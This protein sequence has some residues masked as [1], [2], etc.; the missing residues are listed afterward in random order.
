MKTL[1]I[2][3]LGLLVLAAAVVIGDSSATAE[4]GPT[5]VAT[6]RVG[7]GGYEPYG[8]AVNP[9][10]NRV[11]VTNEGTDNVSV[12]DGATN[13]V[14][15]TVPVGIHPWGIAFN[16]TTNRVYVT[17]NADD[18]VSVIGDSPSGPTSKPTPPS[19]AT[20]TPRPVGAA[21]FP[22]RSGSSRSTAV[23]ALG[24]TLGVLTLGLGAWYARRRFSRG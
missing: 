12:I 10:T 5:V 22:S 9:T 24:L 18:T 16:P 19:T 15:A 14:T 8:V 7:W 6:V 1:R 11:Y 20:P 17:N 2:G 21:D 3:I 13:A 4:G 23:W